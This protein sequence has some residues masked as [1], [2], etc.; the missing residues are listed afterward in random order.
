MSR[1][2]ALEGALERA[3]ERIDTVA[4]ERDAARSA[5]ERVRAIPTYNTGGDVA[6]DFIYVRDLLAA[7]HGTDEPPASM[8]DDGGLSD[9]RKAPAPSVAERGLCGHVLV[10]TYDTYRC[11]LLADHASRRHRDGNTSWPA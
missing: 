11:A 4:D 5:L 8:D 3:R 9:P 6:D 1:E 7:L 2:D 10:G